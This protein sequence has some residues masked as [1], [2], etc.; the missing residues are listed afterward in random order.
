VAQHLDAAGYLGG[1]ELRAERVLQVYG[2]DEGAE[3]VGGGIQYWWPLLGGPDAHSGV[4]QGAG[5][6]GRV[7]GPVPWPAESRRGQGDDVLVDEVDDGAFV[8]AVRKTGDDFRQREPV[9]GGGQVPDQLLSYGV[10]AV[11][12]GVVEVDLA[13][14]DADLV[15]QE[16]VDDEGAGQTGAK[17]RGADPGPVPGPK[18]GHLVVRDEKQLGAHRAHRVPARHD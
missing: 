15:G 6:V 9:A 14:G 3:G 4:G 12:A 10:V 18:T 8:E 2:A 7:G 5:G 16:Q 17:E 1:G 11:S 13:L